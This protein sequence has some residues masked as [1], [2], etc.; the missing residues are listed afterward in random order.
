LA[1]DVTANETDDDAP[2]ARTVD[3]GAEA[4]HPEGGVDAIANVDDVH[5][6]LSLFLTV[7]E[8]ANVEPA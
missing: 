5:P 2:G 8:Y 7:A 4:T 1:G 6:Q 3:A